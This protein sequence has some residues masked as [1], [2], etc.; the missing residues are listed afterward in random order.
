M[1]STGDVG[2]AM[3]VSINTVKGWVRTGKITGVRLPSGHF[4]IPRE[5]LERLR[6]GRQDTSGGWLEYER[7]R[8]GQETE[9]L[10][11]ERTLDWIDSILH[12]ARS[13]GAQPEESLEGKADG[14]RRMHRALASVR[15]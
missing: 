10:D 11:I 5:E 13:Q 3:G 12:L 7:W 6:L 9:E 4:R 2:R 14:V 15:G 1:L 8:R